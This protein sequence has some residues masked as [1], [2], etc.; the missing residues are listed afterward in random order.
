MLIWMIVAAAGAAL[1]I[2]A[3]TV[4][5]RRGLDEIERRGEY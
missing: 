3:C 5:L 1:L 2:W 4:D